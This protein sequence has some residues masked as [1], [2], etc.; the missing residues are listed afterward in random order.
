MPRIPIDNRRLQTE[1]LP[2]ARMAEVSPDAFGA[3]LGRDVQRA[4]ATVQQQ[5]LGPEWDRIN[6]AK[7]DDAT[8]KLAAKRIEIGNRLRQAQGEQALGIADQLEREFEATAAELRQGLANNAQRDAYDGDAGRLGLGLRDAIDGHVLA[9]AERVADQKAEARVSTML[10]SGVANRGDADMAWSD[11]LSAEAT[12]DGHL[13]AR[14]VPEE[15]R[16]AE[17]HKLRSRFTADTIAALADDGNHV[18]ARR[19]FEDNQAELRDPRDLAR[20][21]DLVRSATTKGESQRI[22]DELLAAPGSNLETTMAAAAKIADPELREAVERRAVTML[23]IREKARDE[24]QADLFVN[25]YKIAK[26]DPRGLDAVPMSQLQA[27]DPARRQQLE[28][29]AARQARG[30]KLPWQV[31]K[32][33]RYEIEA[34]AATPDGRARFLATDLRPLLTTMNEDDWQAVAKL[35]TDLRQAGPDS[36]EGAWLNTREDVVNEALAGQGIDPRPYITR[37]G[38]TT[39]NEA[40]IGFR[41]E[42]EIE[43]AAIAADAKRTKV[44]VDDVRKAADTV[45]LR[46]VRLDEWGRDPEVVA[47]T[48]AKD[49]RGAA[50]VPID[51]IAP[52]KVVAI[53]DLI[54]QAGGDPTDDRV[55]RAYAARLIGDRTLLE[56]ILKER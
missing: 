37:D 43:A 19:W 11:L 36:A 49:R 30:E 48:V 55:Q 10:Q 34:G 1:A 12:L 7:V 40:A 54:R 13:K 28:A 17:V 47:A 35:Q 18:A 41:R 26:D 22:V 8:T 39:P 52:G 15:A 32:A 16:R 21:R 25:A 3:G 31:S 27:L 9:Q 2:G 44:T 51:Q 24:A 14:G 20:A 5:V 4:G 42:V 46:K 53:R 6:R 29:W 33:V 50:Y 23:G 45:L 56:Q 38:E